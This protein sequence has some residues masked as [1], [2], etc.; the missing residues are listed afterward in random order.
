MDE[1]LETPKQLAKRVGLSE[2]Q[3]RHLIQARQLEYVMIGCRILIPPGAWG[4]FLDNKKVL[5]CH[6][7]TLDP[8]FTGSRSDNAGTSSGPNEAAAASAALARRTANRLKSPSPSSSSKASDDLG[9]VIPLR[10]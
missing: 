1:R 5:P 4:R 7:A 9:R 3:V 10:S 6:D 8:A 2:R